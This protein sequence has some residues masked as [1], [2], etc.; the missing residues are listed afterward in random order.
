MLHGTKVV[1][2]GTPVPSKHEPKSMSGTVRTSHL[3][4]EELE[5]LRKRTERAYQMDMAARK[6]RSNYRTIR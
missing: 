3:S 4:P 5:E 1:T 6:P 2:S